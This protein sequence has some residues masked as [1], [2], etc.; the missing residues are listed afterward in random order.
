MLQ[1]NCNHVLP[2]DVVGGKQDYPRRI[3]KVLSEGL[4]L[5]IRKHEDHFWY[6][7]CE[8]ESS[9]ASCN[10]SFDNRWELC[11]L[12]CCETFTV[13]FYWALSLNFTVFLCDK[14]E[15]PFSTISTTSFQLVSW[16]LKL[17]PWNPDAHQSSFCFCLNIVLHHNYGRGWWCSPT[18]Q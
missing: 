17:E 15:N 8:F 9:F 7:S 18:G 3:A 16:N 1:C 11:V 10:W 14:L 6:K 4:K 2:D 5:L 12:K 13:V